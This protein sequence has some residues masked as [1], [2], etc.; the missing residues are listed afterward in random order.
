MGALFCVS[1]IAYYAAFLRQS[2]RS[3]SVLAHL[4]WATYLA[5]GAS[6]LF[7]GLTDVLRPIFSPNYLGIA[8]LSIC[9]CIGITGFIG[10]RSRDVVNVI[11]TMRHQ[12]LIES[13]L[14]VAQFL[15]IAFFL[16]FALTSLDGDTNF[17]RLNLTSA[18]QKLASYGLVNTFA[19]MAS[20][21][22]AV[23]IVMAFI[24]LTQPREQGGSLVRAVLLLAASLSYVVYIFAYVGRDGVVYWLMTACAIFLIFRAQF[25]LG[26]LRLVIGTGLVLT[27]AL[28]VPLTAITIS[29]FST[30]GVGAVWSVLE[31]FGSQIHNFSDFSNINRPTTKGAM[32]FP[33]FQQNICLILSI[34]D[35]PSWLD[36]K[37]SVFDQYISQ[38]KEPWLFGTY[39]SDF[40]GDFGYLGSLAVLS[41]YAF[42]CHRACTGHSGK[43]EMSLARLLLIIFLFLGPYWG[44][45]YFRFGIINVFILVNVAFVIFVWLINRS[46]RYNEVTKSDTLQE[47]GFRRRHRAP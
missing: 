23:S 18:S 22:F 14:I 13:I 29:R 8:Y 20:H 47:M 17:N 7:I 2:N 30:S 21:L 27:G 19:G 31:Y 6:A 15:S 35:C 32:N 34:Q 5:L 12:E 10:F 9:I 43:Y 16:P 39:V 41:I 42:V 36:I 11:N 26:R 37:F 33:L 24:R 38:G 1:L 25:P 28:L 45:F 40:V 44:V 3:T 46:G 4:L